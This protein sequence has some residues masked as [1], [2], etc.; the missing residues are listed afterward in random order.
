[1]PTETESKRD[2]FAL[3]GQRRPLISLAGCPPAF[4][5]ELARWHLSGEP[6]LHSE[7]LVRLWGK[8]RG[9]RKDTDQQDQGVKD[10][11]LLRSD[12]KERWQG[13]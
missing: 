12:S 13:K 10:A 11:K 9:G 1:M 7:I 2:S 6:G 3:G 4:Q 5:A 8:G